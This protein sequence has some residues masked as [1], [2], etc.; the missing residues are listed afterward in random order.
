[1]QFQY[2]YNS[3]AV[4]IV[5]EIYFSEEWIELVVSSHCIGMAPCPCVVS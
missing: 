3:P 4:Y 5:N 2:V 1:M